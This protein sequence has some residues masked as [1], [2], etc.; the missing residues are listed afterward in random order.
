MTWPRSTASLPSCATS[1]TYSLDRKSVVWGK[2]GD[3]GGRR[4]LKKKKKESDI[5]SFDGCHKKAGRALEC[6]ISRS[7]IAQPNQGKK[8]ITSSHYHFVLDRGCR[9]TW[10]AKAR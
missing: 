4:I 6:M 1:P 3:L 9:V 2:R 7:H 8:N 10:C 5:G